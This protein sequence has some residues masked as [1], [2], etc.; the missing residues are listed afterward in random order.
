ML[1]A[2]RVT[3][4]YFELL[5]FRPARGREFTT[6]DEIAGTGPSVILSDRIWHGRF[7]SDPNII[8]RVIRLDALRFPPS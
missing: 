1:H 8:G 5:G 4:G 3:A 2:F 6:R 7:A